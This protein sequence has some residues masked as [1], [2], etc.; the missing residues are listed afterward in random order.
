M[1]K[2]VCEKSS[3]ADPN[4]I[5]TCTVCE[6]NLKRDVLSVAIQFVYAWMDIQHKSDNI[7]ADSTVCAY[8]G[9][10]GEGDDGLKFCAA[11]KLVKYCSRECQSAHR[12]QHKKECK[13][14][15]AELHDEILF[16]QPP[17]KEDCQICF[18]PMPLLDTG[19]RYMACCGKILCSGCIYAPV[20]DNQ[21][22][23]AAEEKCPFC[24]TPEHT[25][26]E[27]IVERYKKRI[28]VNDAEAIYTLG[29]FYG[30]GS[31]GFPQNNAKAL[32]LWHRAG[33]FGH[34]HSYYNI[35]TIY[36]NGNGVERDEEKALRYFE[37]AAIRGNVNARH[38][39]GVVE[40][41]AGNMDKALKHWMIAAGLG[42]G[43]S[44][45]N[46]Q[47][48]FRIGQATKNDYANALRLCQAYLDEIKSDQRDEAAAASD[49]YEYYLVQGRNMGEVVYEQFV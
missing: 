39:L 44:L 14:R 33:E 15:A 35:G 36:Y 43:H 47:N 45:K 40:R 10:G 13:K 49:E 1:S 2:C 30:Q 26:N 31:L 37:L 4:R 46:I 12:P 21:G 34:T 41:K 19:Y 5:N 6:E 7:S 22:N 29:C 28:E 42:H 9:K 20:Y 23:K 16:R 11:C 27:E 48:L 25:T 24:R 8:C 17:P 18:L 38:N 3:S 32:E